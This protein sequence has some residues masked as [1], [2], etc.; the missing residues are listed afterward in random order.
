MNSIE[1]ETKLFGMRRDFYG[2]RRINLSDGFRP[3]GGMLGDFCVIEHGGRYHFFAIE[4][5]LQEGTPFYPGHEVFFCHASIADLLN[6]DVHEPVMW[7]RPDSWEN[8][9]VWAPYII[10]WKNRFLMAYTGLN[11]LCS[12]DIGFA[13]S[14]DLFRWER[15]PDNPLS[16]AKDCSWAFWRTDGIASCRDPHL[17]IENGRLFMTY[18]ANTSAGASCIAL[19]STDDSNHWKCHGPILTGRTDGYE[20]RLEGNHPQGQLESSNL[21]RRNDRWYLLTH[22]VRHDSPIKNWI[23]K[24]DRMDSFDYSSGRDF[25]SGAY[26]V[27]FVKERGTKSLLAT[28]GTIRFGEVDWSVANPEVRFINDEEQ[29]R[30][31]FL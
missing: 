21:F 22:E 8:G 16:P 24:S 13:F 18:T 25:W 29:L 17:F 23:Y 30:A 4:R 19:T 27:E 3:V 26:T 1:F 6:W 2:H 9:H 7:V 14:D 28:S 5:R 15:S 10:R 12:Q 20:A 31:W 11:H